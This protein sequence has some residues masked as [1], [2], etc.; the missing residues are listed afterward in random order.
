MRSL[1][2]ILFFSL[3]S[4]GVWAEQM[5]P[6]VLH[7]IQVDYGPIAKVCAQL[8]QERLGEFIELEDPRC[9]GKDFRFCLY[10]SQYPIGIYKM[11]FM[12]GACEVQVMGT[13]INEYQNTIECKD[14]QGREICGG[15]YAWAKPKKSL[16]PPFILDL[17]N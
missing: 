11:H 17:M 3:L 7:K 8:D 12:N 6:D 5:D 4:S 13:G 2:S 15:Q 9:D 1:I 16:I 14:L 10:T